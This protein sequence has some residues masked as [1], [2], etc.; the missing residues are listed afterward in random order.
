MTTYKRGLG[1]LVLACLGGCAQLPEEE[2]SQ[3]SLPSYVLADGFNSWSIRCPLQ[4]ITLTDY[5]DLTKLYK[6]NGAEKSF[7]E[8]CTEFD[9]TSRVRRRG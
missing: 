5:R 3:I 7:G 2:P 9:T 6:S 1:I 8:F 4:T